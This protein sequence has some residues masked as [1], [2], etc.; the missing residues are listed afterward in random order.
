[1]WDR[2][3]RNSKV[4]PKEHV[5]HNHSEQLK[6]VLVLEHWIDISHHINFNSTSTVGMAT[7]YISCLMREATET[8]LYLSNFNREKGFTLSHTWHPVFDLLKQ[9]RDAPMGKQGQ[10]ELDM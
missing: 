7:R 5:R 6:K 3:R 10:A 1:M 8:Q 2:T 4:R 9:Y